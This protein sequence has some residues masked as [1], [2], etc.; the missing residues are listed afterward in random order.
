MILWDRE[1]K[2]TIPACAGEPL[3]LEGVRVC[4]RDYPR[5]CGGTL[6]RV[7]QMQLRQGLSP[8]VRGNL[9]FWHVWRYPLGTIPACAGEPV[10]VCLCPCLAGDYPRVCGGTVVA[11]ALRRE[12]DGLSPRVRGNPRQPT[13]HGGCP[14][15]IPACA[16]EPVATL[17]RGDTMRDYPRV[18]GGTSSQT[19]RR[20][21]P[22]GL[23][24][25]VRGNRRA[26]V[27]IGCP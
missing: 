6:E 1:Q 27:G 9:D 23:S 17:Q 20:R 11:D 15:T 4:F 19:G 13:G 5:V 2:G 24:P 7:K 3:E 22:G 25:R 16:G 26:S 21:A 18:C 8:R 14:G 12:K 10:G